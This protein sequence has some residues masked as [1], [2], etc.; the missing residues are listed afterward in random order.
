MV[1]STHGFHI[2]KPF[3]QISTFIFKFTAH[4]TSHSLGRRAR[5]TSH[6]S[7]IAQIWITIFET[8]KLHQRPTVDIEL[9]E[10]AGKPFDDVRA[11]VKPSTA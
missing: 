6:P 8:I 5:L 3:I 9:V 2:G 10:E 11:T 4:R 1:V 7:S